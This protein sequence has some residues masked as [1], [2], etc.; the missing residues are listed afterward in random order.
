[1]KY[2]IN[3][4]FTINTKENGEMSLIQASILAAIM[5]GSTFQGIYTDGRALMAQPSGAQWFIPPE[6]MTDSEREGDAMPSRSPLH[7]NYTM[8]ALMAKYPMVINPVV[9]RNSYLLGLWRTESITLLSAAENDDD[10]RTGIIT[11]YNDPVASESPSLYLA[12]AQN[13]FIQA[14]LGKKAVLYYGLSEEEPRLLFLRDN[15]IKALRGNPTISAFT[16]EVPEL[17]KYA[18][19]PDQVINDAGY[20]ESLMFARERLIVQKSAL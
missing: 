20:R 7:D 18:F 6:G 2:I 14:G 19:I 11:G 1:M 15:S 8:Q 4:L 9:A 12:I 3:D 16:V 13:A 17:D 10:L 5:A